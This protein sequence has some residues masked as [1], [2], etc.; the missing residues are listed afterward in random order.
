MCDC[1]VRFVFCT[2]G[3]PIWEKRNE[4][5]YGKEKISINKYSCAHC[6][7]PAADSPCPVAPA[8][9]SVERNP[10]CLGWGQYCFCP[11]GP[12]SFNSMCTE[13][14]KSQRYQYRIHSNQRF[15]GAV[16][17]GNRCTRF[18]PYFRAVRKLIINLT[19]KEFDI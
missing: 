19:S 6:E 2:G 5:N 7:H 14:G 15:L 3:Y 8:L 12:D 1:S 18:V 17:G 11:A 16:D 10:N 9:F 4:V 13:Q